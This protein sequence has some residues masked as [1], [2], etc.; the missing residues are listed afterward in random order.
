M[1]R[2][3]RFKIK[4]IG[5]TLSRRVTSYAPVASRGAFYRS[6]RRCRSRCGSFRSYVFPHLVHEVALVRH[7]YRPVGSPLQRPLP[8]G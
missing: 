6:R 4:P 8:P 5:G 3:D 1:P 7:L 2:A